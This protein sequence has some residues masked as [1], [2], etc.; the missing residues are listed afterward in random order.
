VS[1]GGWAA[2]MHR[3]ERAGMDC[4]LGR[5]KEC[6]LTDTNEA[7]E[8]SESDGLGEHTEGGV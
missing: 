4:E 2:T 5:A 7:S 8:G 1:A 3:H 6:A